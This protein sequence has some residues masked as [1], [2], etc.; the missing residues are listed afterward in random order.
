MKVFPLVLLSAALLSGC[1]GSGGSDGASTN[2]GSNVNT[3]SGSNNNTGTTPGGSTDTGNTG[4]SVTPAPV[5]P[6]DE[7]DFAEQMLNAVNQAR[8]KEQNCGGQMMPAVPAL[9]WD[10]DLQEA[11][12][13]H[14]SDMANGGFMSHTGSDN[15]SPDQRIADT[16]YSANA[17]AENV[18]AGQKSISAVM[19]A[20]MA[21]PGHCT[22]I[23]NANVTQM[24]AAMVENVDTQYDQYWTQVFARPRG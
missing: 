21:S 15:S 20:W 8:A 11:A 7:T 6:T 16:G 10:Y 22:N 9:T 14:S 2:T 23:M 1:G 24:G 19:A 13:R 17:W 4:G 5:G 18:A 3:G 12:Y